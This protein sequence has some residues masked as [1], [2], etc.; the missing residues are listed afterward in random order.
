MDF[1]LKLKTE[2]KWSRPGKPHLSVL[3]PADKANAQSAAAVSSGQI[4]DRAQPTVHK[5]QT[6]AKKYHILSYK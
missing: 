3:S 4:Q 5:G 1:H 6:P 2:V